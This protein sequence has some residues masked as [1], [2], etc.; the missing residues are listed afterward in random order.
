MV[1]YDWIRGEPRGKLK[2]QQ[3]QEDKGDCIDCKLCVHVCP[4]GIDIRNGTQL[5]CVNCTA[6]IDACDKMMENVGLP[7]G[8]I[9]YASE[10]NIEKKANRHGECKRE[11]RSDEQCSRMSLI[12]S[13]KNQKHCTASRRDVKCS[14]R[15]K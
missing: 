4:T 8:L 7:K 14:K 13:T 1:A 12:I 2:K 6:C 15:A 5:E 11:N 3:K 10:E 9:R